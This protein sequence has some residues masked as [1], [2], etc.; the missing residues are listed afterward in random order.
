MPL[1]IGNHSPYKPQPTYSPVATPTCGVRQQQHT[2]LPNGLR[3]SSNQYLRRMPHVKNA[4]SPYGHLGM[5]SGHHT[6]SK[7]LHDP[8]A[9]PAPPMSTFTSPIT[10]MIPEDRDSANYSMISDQDREMYLNASLI[11]QIQIN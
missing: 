2:T 6:F 5:G 3:Y 11:S 8:L 1:P 10:Q 9:M 7:L 4:E